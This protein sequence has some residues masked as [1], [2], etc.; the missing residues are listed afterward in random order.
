MAA[1]RVNISKY[2]VSAI[3]TPDVLK[4]LNPGVVYSARNCTTNFEITKY[5]FWENQKLFTNTAST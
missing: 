3:A 1:T 5:A 4:N 2:R